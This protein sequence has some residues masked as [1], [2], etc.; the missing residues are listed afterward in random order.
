[1]NDYQAGLR[2]AEL[3]ARLESDTGSE[4]PNRPFNR[5]R[6]RNVASLWTIAVL[7][8][9][10]VATWFLDTVLAAEIVAVVTAIAIVAA[11]ARWRRTPDRDAA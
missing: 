5:E 3:R 6:L 2:S 4:P 10:G 11:F 9:A 8:I 1:M 7:V